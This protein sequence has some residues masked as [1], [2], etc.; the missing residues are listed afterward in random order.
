MK[1]VLCLKFSRA[2]S[3][4]NMVELK[5]STRLI[6]REDFSTFIRRESF[7]SHRNLF[8]FLTYIIRLL[9]KPWLFILHQQ[10]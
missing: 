10:I 6:A 3:R 9:I 4:V 5:T 1:F 8:Y 2:I 7:K